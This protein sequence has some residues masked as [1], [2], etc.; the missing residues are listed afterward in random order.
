MMLVLAGWEGLRAMELAGLDRADVLD[1]AVPPVMLIRGKGGRERVV[2]LSPIVL[3]ELDRYGL[4]RDGPVFPRRDGQPG[5]N[6]ATRISN[7]VSTYL[8]EAGLPFT[9]HQCRHRFGTEMY[10]N[11]RDLRMVQEMMGHAGPTTTSGYVAFSPRTAWEAV[12]R[13]TGQLDGSAR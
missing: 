2:P 10:R 4:P 9:L 6:S 7:I 13:I 8:H 5:T 11:S 12:Q 1:L 3:A